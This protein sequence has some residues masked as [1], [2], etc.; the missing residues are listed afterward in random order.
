MNYN[1][2]ITSNS[3]ES[4]LNDLK[5][6]E[7]NQYCYNYIKNI[8]PSENEDKI[9]EHAEISAACFRQANEYYIASQT[10]TLSTKPLLLSYA[11]N[12]IL[13]GICNLKYFDEKILGNFSRHGFEVKNQDIVDNVLNLKIN[14]K[15]HGAVISLLKIFNNEITPQKIELYKL[16]RHIPGLE[17]VYYK[18]TGEVSL[19]SRQDKNDDSEFVIIGDNLTPEIEEITQEFGLVGQL[20]SRDN[21]Y[22]CYLNMSYKRKISNGEFKKDNILYK[23][24]LI[25]PE[26]FNEGI[27]DINVMVYCY[28]LIMAYGMLVRY[29]ADK[30]EKYIDR[31]SSKEATLIE[32]SIYNAVIHFYYQAHFILFGYFYKEDS[33]N[34]LDVKRVIKN[35][36]TDIMNNIINEI[37][38]HNFRYNSHDF[39]PWSKNYR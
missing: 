24:Y 27:K 34:D 35:S 18:T 13:K 7:Q 2:K 37:E 30:W 36:T 12:N 16:L 6:F 23:Q 33:Y 26:K 39:L 9:K 31:R 25:L 19:L 29:N 14:L 32:L 5:M 28:L 17:E 11:F 1:Y 8:F 22:Y 21:N 20:N 15:S 3:F 38:E 10:V 4:T